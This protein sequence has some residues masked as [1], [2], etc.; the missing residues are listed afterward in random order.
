[1]NATSG[2]V[3]ALPQTQTG[4]AHSEEL[5]RSVYLAVAG[6]ACLPIGLLWDI[7]HH[8]TIGRD[9]FWTPAH[10]IIQL[11]GIVPALLF[12]SIAL[13]TTFRGTEHERNASVSFWG[14]RAPLGVWV[15]VW[16]AIAMMTSAP[17]DDWWHNRYGLD[18]K[19]VSP[20]H[21]VLGLGMFAVGMGVL[22]FAFSSQNRANS[23]NRTRSG[24]IC[25]LAVGVMIA[26]WADFATE[27]TWPNLQ[28]ASHFYA[29]VSTPFPLLLLL[30]ARASKVR[31]GAT[32]AA[33][34]YMFIY[35]GMI[36]VLPLFPAH[37]KL[38]PVYHPV[39]HMVPPAFPLLLIV[40]A[41]AID[42]ISWLFTR[43]SKSIA[44]PPASPGATLPRPRW[45][46]DWLLAL[47][48]AAVFLAIIFA[49]QWPFSTF[50]L[51]DGA[52]NRF[53]AR[54]GHWPYFAKPGDWV[55]RFWDWDNDPI[56]FKG[57][58]LAFLR[59]F[60]SARVG[61]L[62]GSYLLRLKR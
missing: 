45:W 54:S 11:G 57:M 53:F 35:I 33:A 44:Q 7:S 17:F 22:L 32:I 15:T 59:A 9:T 31:A 14:F 29:V 51:S 37:P 3:L 40:P 39:D 4:S 30:A 34:T 21:A 5:P 38:A 55:N 49:V 20:P 10:I 25:A 2:D 41:V 24:L 58:A 47:L 46:R 6:L 42:V 28:H 16:G 12:A 48:F 23:G 18:V 19:I 8:S 1:M 27:F 26:M 60:I 50:L 36:L 13:K 56:T 62:L 52:D 61:L 43:S